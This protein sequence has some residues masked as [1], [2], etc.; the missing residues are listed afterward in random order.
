MLSQTILDRKLD[1]AAIEQQRERIAVRILRESAGLRDANF[2]T[3]STSDLFELYVH[4]D[5]LFFDGEINKFFE[6]Q[7]HQLKFRLSSR[8]TSTGGTTTY[9]RTRSPVKKNQI[10]R[11][12]EIAISTTLLFN[13]PF[14]SAVIK[15]GGVKTF[16]RLDALQRI[17]EHELVHLIEMLLWDDSS[18]ARQRFKSI[19]RRYFGHLESNHQLL[20]PSETAQAVYGIVTGDRVSFQHQGKQMRG[21]VNGITR[22]ATVLVPSRQGEVYADNRRYRRFY[23]PVDRLKKIS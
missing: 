21:F 13:T 8:M 11:N 15:V 10:N 20:T 19:V 16:H 18:C 2:Q 12:F 4:Y 22:R 17:F 14:D 3:I 5:E 7:D 23:V 6:R 9:M 1:L